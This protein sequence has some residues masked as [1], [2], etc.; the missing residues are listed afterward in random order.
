MSP[1]TTTTTT[2][3]VPDIQTLWPDVLNEPDTLS[4]FLDPS[5]N[6]LPLPLLEVILTQHI[7]PAFLANIHPNINPTTGRKLPRPAGGPLA[8]QDF[9]ESQKWKKHLGIGNVILWCLKHFDRD[10]YER[11]WHLLIPPIMTML[12]DYEPKYKLIGVIIVREMM[13]TVPG[14]LLKRTGVE[15]LIRSALINCLVHLQD[16]ESPNLIRESIT[17]HVELTVLTTR[18]GEQAYFDQLCGLLGE[19]VIG[20]VWFYGY[21]KENVILAS[22]EA[23]PRLITALGVGCI[24]FLK[25]L[26]TQLVDPLLPKPPRY[27]PIRLQ[28]ASTEALLCVMNECAQQIDV[29]KAGMIV[30]AVCRCWVTLPPQNSVDPKPGKRSSSHTTVMMST[31]MRWRYYV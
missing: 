26:I 15:G 27:V 18:I 3:T 20:G 2:T 1:T 5:T 14:T 8:S 7:K 28:I 31:K 21:E 23:L 25:A 30:D 24:R 4:T 6:I 17:A 29:K 22:V 10:Y 9:Y 16:E 12:D 13:K 19:G 11:I